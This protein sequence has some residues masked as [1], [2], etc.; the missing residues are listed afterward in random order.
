VSAA[1]LRVAVTRDDRED[2]AMARALEALGFLPVSCA[3]IREEAAPDDGALALAAAN[4]ESYAWIVVSSS[5]A[6]RAVSAARGA[7][8]WPRSLRGGAAGASTSRALRELGLTNVITGNRGGADAL[9]GALLRAEHWP[10]TRVLAPR[11]ADGRR[12]VETGLRDAGAHVDEPVAY[13]TALVSAAVIRRRWRNGSP[14]AAVIA[15]PSAARSLVGALGAAVLRELKCVVA[16]GPT[17]AA[18]LRELDVPA[19][20]APSATFEAAAQTLREDLAHPG[21]PS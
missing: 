16:I 17:T 13:R 19:R 8:A 10:G 1:G 12:V 14:Q 20:V 9:L 5:R 2:G 18:A 7:R 3:V 15:S 21:G 4:L 6:V 11:A